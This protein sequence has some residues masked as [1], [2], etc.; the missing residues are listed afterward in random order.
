MLVAIVC[1]PLVFDTVEVT[2]PL[3]RVTVV[4]AEVAGFS[5]ELGL[6]LALVLGLVDWEGKPVVVSPV[7]DG[8]KPVTILVVGRAVDGRIDS[9]I[10][11]GKPVESPAADTTVDPPLGNGSTTIPVPVVS[12]VAI[13]VEVIG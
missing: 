7:L 11:E 13:G 6:G 5:E 4:A 12:A 8:P 9:A 3:V 10:V 1:P 2:M